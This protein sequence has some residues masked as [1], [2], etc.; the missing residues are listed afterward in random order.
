MLDAYLYGGH[1]VLDFV[2]VG[3][4]GER[5]VHLRHT[6]NDRFDRIGARKSQCKTVSELMRFMDQWTDPKMVREALVYRPL[7]VE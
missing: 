7:L 2:R 5:P 1:A 4:I 6:A 3:R